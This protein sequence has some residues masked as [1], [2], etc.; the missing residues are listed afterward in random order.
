MYGIRNNAMNKIGGYMAKDEGFPNFGRTLI[1]GLKKNR[2]GK[3][4]SLLLRIMEDLRK[5]RPGFA[6]RVP[7]ASI[8][9]VSVLNLRSAIV[10]AAAKEKIGVSTS[11]DEEY[12]Y[13]WR[14]S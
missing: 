2:K 14:A 9:G 13:V 8:G 4:H 3:H 1:S 12:F 6:V 10:R 7:L 11:S 5:S